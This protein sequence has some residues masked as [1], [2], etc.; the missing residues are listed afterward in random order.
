VQS[1]SLKMEYLDPEE[2]FEMM[3]ADELEMMNE[4]DFTTDGNLITIT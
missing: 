2:E 3:H 1:K 4:M